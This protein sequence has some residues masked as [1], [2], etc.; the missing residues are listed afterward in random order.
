MAGTQPSIHA[1]IGSVT[2]PRSTLL[3]P[4]GLPFVGHAL[5]FLRDKPGF[6][7]GCR[8][9]YGETVRLS[10]AGPTLLITAPEDVRHVLVTAAGQ[11]SKSAR[12][13]GDTARRRLGT[14]LFTV[15]DAVHARLRS[16]TVRCFHP[17]RLADRQW[18]LAR[19]CAD[20]AETAVR[21]GA[22]DSGSHLARF[23]AASVVDLLLGAEESRRRP[24]WAAALEQRRRADEAAFAVL[25][26]SGMRSRSGRRSLSR[27]VSAA[28]REAADPDALLRGLYDGSEG[29]A[30]GGLESGIEQLL[31]AAYETT[32]M[33]L[34]WTIDLLARH[35]RWQESGVEESVAERI[36]SES[37]RLYPPTWLFVRVATDDNRL[38][39]GV[40]AAAG[41]K[42]YLSPYVSQRSSA[43]FVAASTFDPDRFLPDRRI[44]PW[45][46]FPFGAGTRSCLGERLARRI[47]AMFVSTL[48]RRA[49]LAP[50][51]QVPPRPVGR[52][53]LRPDRAIRVV[54]SSRSGARMP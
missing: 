3:G 19:H 47:G 42:I 23:V 41:A 49:R 17:Q 54:V 30:E 8:E 34:A 18:L 43:A 9:R 39:S 28:I 33:M 2:P 37:L 52:L 44:D 13:V 4:V 45:R 21:Q 36:V 50:L 12:L 35:P 16:R 29:A 6:L 46:Y 27:L 15:A 20:F 31:L 32:A 48:L 22:V 38:P 11:Y 26:L 5:P 25:P 7:L 53:T 40:E 1:G 10:L 51:A 24:G 14:S